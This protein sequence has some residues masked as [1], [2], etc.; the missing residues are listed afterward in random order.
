[1]SSSP[2]SKRTPPSNRFEDYVLTYEVG[3][4]AGLFP[5]SNQKLSYVQGTIGSPYY[6]QARQ[7]VDLGFDFNFDGKIYKKLFIHTGGWCVLSD[8]LRTSANQVLGDVGVGG[9][10]NNNGTI[11]DSFGSYNHVL[12]AVWFDALRN[13]WRFTNDTGPG[14]TTPLSTY[15][16]N[17]GISSLSDLSDLNSGK[18]TMPAGIDSTS[19]GVKYC[20][21]ESG[22]SGKYFLVRWKSFSYNKTES[23]NVIIFDLVIYENG[24]IEFRYSPRLGTPND[25]AEGATIGIF[26]NG[27]SVA[28]PRYR[29]FSSILR[30]DTRPVHVNGGSSYDGSYTELDEYTGDL[31]KYGANLKTRLHWPGVGQ[32]GAIFRFSPPA[33]RRRQNRSIL[34]LRESSS[35]VSDGSSYFNDQNTI[36]FTSQVVEYPT[37][38]PTSLRTSYNSSQAV[39]VNELYASGS[40]QVTRTLSP[41]MFDS[42]L[43]DA[44]L[45]GKRR[46]GG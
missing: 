25:T 11:S 32:F 5:A 35:F 20:L 13:T 7:L 31:A 23:T 19:G 22:S 42:V 30:P 3:P 38:L 12:L 46:S 10:G 34:N 33:I 14:G 2:K 44:I 4:Q 15:L 24:K 45:D 43:E 9:S 27:E 41:G 29:D 1:M 36:P 40:I 18:I 28:S 21:G 6:T 16:P 8:P 26:A 37:M 17:L 39:Y